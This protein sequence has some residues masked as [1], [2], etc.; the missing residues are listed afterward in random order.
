MGSPVPSMETQF[1]PRR[2]SRLVLLGILAAGLSVA[3][4]A[5]GQT[6]HRARLSQDLADRLQ[7]R[8]EAPSEIIVTASDEAVDRL[9]A[10]YGARLKKRLEGGSVLEATGGQLDAI[11]QDPDVDHGSGNA[12][13]RR[14]MAVTTAAT[15]ADQVWAGLGGLR[16]YDGRGVTVAVIDSGVSASGPLADRV[17]V[18]KDFTTG[19]GPGRDEFGHG[20]HVAG[21]VAEGD[22]DGYGGMAPGAWIANLRALGADG[23]GTTDAVIEAIGWAGANRRRYNIRIIN[24]SLGHPVFE[25]YRDDPLCR[26]AQRAVDAGVLVVAAAGNFGKTA[27]GRPIVGGIVSPGNLPSALT[28]GAINT[29]GT[30]LRSDDVMATYSSRGPA[31]LVGTLTQEVV[32]T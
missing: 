25:S 23:S 16:G 10:R 4:P 29:R 18:S 26:A 19:R 9:V 21:I 31:Y 6:R 30:A 28:V 22:R 11:S 1:A 24:L 2:I 3:A 8:V 14:M 7:R 17:V 12:V 32:A 13:V 27:E 5:A 15:G 20:T